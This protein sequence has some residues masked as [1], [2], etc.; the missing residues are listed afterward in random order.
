MRKYLIILTTTVLLLGVLAQ[1]TQASSLAWGPSIESG[2]PTFTTPIQIVDGARY[3]FASRPLLRHFWTQA[4]NAALEEWGLPF[5]VTQSTTLDPYNGI[6]AP[7]AIT[8]AAADV[9]GLWGAGSMEGIGGVIAAPCMD[10]ELQCGYAVVDIKDIE[11]YFRLSQ[12]HL[13][14]VYGKNT[15][16]MLIAHEIGHALGFGHGGNGVMIGSVHVNDQERT[17]AAAYYGV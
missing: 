3:L 15:A 17:L 1:T 5:E 8:L 12:T 11:R 14:E 4:R 16:R 2:G 10:Q 6:L 7:G 9:E 13:N